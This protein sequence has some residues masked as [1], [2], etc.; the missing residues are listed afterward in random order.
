MRTGTGG[1]LVLLFAAGISCASYRQTSQATK[2]V[3][4]VKVTTNRDDVKNCRHLAFVDSTDSQRGCGLT[5]QPTTEECLRYQVALA[6][7]DT[8][9]SNGLVGNAYDCSGQ[10]AAV[11]Q[12]SPTEQ[13]SPVPQQS[14][15]PLPSPT[16]HP[17]AAP[18]VSKTSPP[19]RGEV[20]I[21]QSRET[22]RGCVYLD[23]MDLRTECPAEDA[24]AS[25]DCV[26]DRAAKAGGNA[27]LIEGS[28][29]LIF[30]CKENP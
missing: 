4:K 9:L 11:P 29:A 22:L 24:G 23:E 17:T 27:V 7:G 16:P 19:G 30:S 28:R 25:S 5:V 13:P 8:L 2:S 14:P 21:V 20:R 1:A 26:A 15:T 10:S 6:G 18:A 3:W 12:P